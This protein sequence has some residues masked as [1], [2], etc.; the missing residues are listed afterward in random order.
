[1]NSGTLF[2]LQLDRDFRKVLESVLGGD[3]VHLDAVEFTGLPCPRLMHVKAHYLLV[4]VLF[5]SCLWG[6]G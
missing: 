5:D 6:Y 3:G 4:Y 2:Q 1:M